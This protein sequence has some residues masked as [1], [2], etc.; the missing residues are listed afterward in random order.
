MYMEYNLAE[1][2]KNLSKAF[3]LAQA[4]HDIFITRTGLKF[5]LYLEEV[6]FSEKDGLPVLKLR[7]KSTF[8]KPKDIKPVAEKLTDL[9]SDWKLCKHGADPKY[10]K[11]AKGG[12]PCGKA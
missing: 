2:R 11:F 5:R 4:G 8:A 7:N 12:K 1:F 10:C 3:N 9:K 6:S